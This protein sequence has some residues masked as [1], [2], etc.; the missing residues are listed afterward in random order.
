MYTGESG[1]QKWKRHTVFALWTTF[2][3]ANHDYQQIMKWSIC[4]KK[5]QEQMQTKNDINKNQGLIT[6][7]FFVFQ[8]PPF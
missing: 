4:G 8:L 1:S 5:E 2:I 6:S 3:V 7:N